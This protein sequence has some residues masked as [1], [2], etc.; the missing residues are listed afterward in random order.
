[1]AAPRYV[2]SELHLSF[3]GSD[4][5]EADM[6]VKLIRFV[7]DERRLQFRRIYESRF[8]DLLGTTIALIVLSFFA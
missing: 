6:A 3:G 8:A 5:M 1:M 7:H 4:P 2:T